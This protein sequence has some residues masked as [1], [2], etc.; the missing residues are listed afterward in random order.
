MTNMENDPSDRSFVLLPTALC[1]PALVGMGA[2]ELNGEYTDG[3]GP[4]G[5]AADAPHAGNAHKMALAT[6][7]AVAA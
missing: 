6:T 1:I 3:V 2:I 5:G 4:V 7:T